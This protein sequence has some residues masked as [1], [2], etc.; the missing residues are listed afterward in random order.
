MWF[1]YLIKMKSERGLYSINMPETKME[2]EKVFKLKHNFGPEANG[3]KKHT[4]KP[5]CNLEESL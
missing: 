3:Q 5:R 2:G 1:V 4:S